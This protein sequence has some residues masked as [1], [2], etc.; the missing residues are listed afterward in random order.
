MEVT[1]FFL[2]LLPNATPHTDCPLFP[3]YHCYTYVFMS[4]QGY[5]HDLMGFIS[6]AY[7]DSKE[8]LFTAAWAPY[9]S[10][11]M[12][13]RLQ[14]MTSSLPLVLRVL[15]LSFPP[16]P[17]SLAAVDRVDSLWLSSNCKLSFIS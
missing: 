4:A 13:G 16:C 6:V 15:T 3:D 17:L 12:L 5:K 8:E 11:S 2:C 10:T 1:F 14:S 9:L 7:K